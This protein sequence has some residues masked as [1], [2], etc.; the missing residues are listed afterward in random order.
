VR[1]AIV[2]AGGHGRVAAECLELAS[3]EDL[4]IVFFD[5]A[6]ETIPSTSDVPILGPVPHL[7][8]DGRF[9]R[10]FVA[11]GDNRA[12]RRITLEL[13]DAGKTLLTILHPKS[14]IS[15]RATVAT[16][17]IA[18][19]GVVVNRGA[20]VGR[21]VILNTLS[22]VG[23]DC[24]VED[25]AQIAPGVN[26]GGGATVGRGAFLGIGAKVVPSVRI[27][28]WSIVGAGSVVL[29]D[30]PERSFCIGTPAKAV[31]PLREDEAPDDDRP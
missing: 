25:F 23:H 9:D 17:T 8:K 6:W 29:R 22:S 2:G 1:I 21:G 28:A 20:H 7:T 5:D 18:I 12:R 10:V 15:P 4:E 26:L 19:A 14:V 30:L 16:G 3:N 27:G 31:R 11:V 24:T 13:L